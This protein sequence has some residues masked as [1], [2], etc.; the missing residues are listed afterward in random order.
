MIQLMERQR[1]TG[2]K[3]FPSVPKRDD[4]QV[5]METK[6][7]KLEA[8]PKAPAEVSEEAFASMFGGI[9]FGSTKN[10]DH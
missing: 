4:N 8:K 3:I 2:V 1:K 10:Q 7:A 5:L 6:P 9:D